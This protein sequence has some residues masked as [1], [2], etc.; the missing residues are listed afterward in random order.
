MLGGTFRGRF[1]QKPFDMAMASR[2]TATGAAG[3]CHL[4]N[5]GQSLF[6]NGLPN[7][8]GMDAEAVTER[9]H[10]ALGLCERG[11]T[12]FMIA[13]SDRCRHNGRTRSKAANQAGRC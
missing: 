2:A 3:F 9:T 10:P 12:Q 8:V 13:V 1:R 5:G 6:I 4:T 11:G 7:F